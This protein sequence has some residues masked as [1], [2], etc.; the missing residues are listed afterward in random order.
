MAVINPL[1]VY[2]VKNLLEINKMPDLNKLSI[3]LKL[4]MILGLIAIYVGR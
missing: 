1:L 2:V 3:I 4:N